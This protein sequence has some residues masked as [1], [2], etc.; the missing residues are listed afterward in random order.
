L[1]IQAFNY[2]IR[3]RSFQRALKLLAFQGFSQAG[4]VPANVGRPPL[5]GR[6]AVDG[7]TLITTC[8]QAKQAPALQEAAA[9]DALS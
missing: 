1:G 8:R 9:A 5:K 6:S 3:D 4:Y 7:K 2:I